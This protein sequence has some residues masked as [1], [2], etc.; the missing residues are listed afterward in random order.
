MEK[1][2]TK[3]NIIAL[4]KVY[5]IGESSAIYLSLKN[6]SL[7][8]KKFMLQ[9]TTFKK[10]FSFKKAFI[11]LDDSSNTIKKELDFLK[12][13]RFKDFFVLLNK[14][15]ISMIDS[16]SSNFFIKPLKIFD[17]HEEIY[18]RIKKI[19]VTSY[20]WRLDRSNLNFCGKNNE[21]VQLTEKEY[22]FL[23][24]LL[25]YK[26]HLLDKEYLL[27]KI[28]KISSENKTQ[29]RETRVVETLVSRIRKKLS[30]YN[31]AP[32]L[33]KVKRGYKILV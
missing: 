27:K 15:N 13:K 14:R 29:M 8:S 1:E 17:L 9:K 19:N 3:E 24:L 18:R 31:D 32:K 33:L 5:Y 12:Q 10:E 16:N 23:Y 28:W 22:N 25:N 6:L 4:F 30:K 26:D 11:I 7:N 2:T 21:Y 20:K